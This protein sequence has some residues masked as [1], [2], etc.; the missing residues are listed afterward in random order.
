MKIAFTVGSLSGGG[1]ERVIAR[2]ATR[3]CEK[4]HEVSVFLI[5][6]ARIDYPICSDI[7]VRFIRPRI[8][9]R[10]I[11]GV[12]RKRKYRK[13]ILKASPDVVISFTAAV[14]VFVLEALKGTGIKTVVSERNNPYVDPADAGL[15]KK[16]DKLYF[17][18][19]GVVFQTSDA[20]AYF[21]DAI[22]KDSE[23]ILNPLDDSLPTPYAGEREKRIVSVGRLEKQKNQTLLIEAFSELAKQF[24]E[25]ILEIYGEGSLRTSLE[26]KIEQLELKTRVFLKG[27]EKDV[28]S[29]ISRAKMFVLSSDYEGI[30]NALIEAMAIGLPVV[31]T[32]HPIGG[33]RAVI[34]DGENG[35]LTPVGDRK[36]LGDAMRAILEDAE[37]SIKMG[38]NATKIRERLSVEKIAEQ[39]LAY[40]ERVIVK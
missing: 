19:D 11:R 40:L 24:P 39:W 21:S 22:Q 36:A 8:N 10:G 12:L 38:E 29:K 28:L 5:A 26:N 2:L 14:N 9:I 7:C 16:R 25:Y 15:R 34:V 13:E 3:L 31:S 35:L 33:A 30:S 1:A 32:D 23:I 37:I 20:K 27:Y 18:A 6:N 4:G 17:H